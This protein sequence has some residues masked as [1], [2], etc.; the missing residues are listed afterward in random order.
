VSTSPQPSRAH[1]TDIKLTIFPNPF[2]DATLIEF[3]LTSAAR[4]E[5]V[6][7]DI[8]G[9]KITELAARAFEA[10]T[11]RLPWNGTTATAIPVT[12]GLYLLQF[13]SPAITTTRKLTIIR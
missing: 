11:H 12:S 3:Q 1:A 8:A 7:Y 13:R 9:R 10:G 2:N 5:L 6:I 4:I